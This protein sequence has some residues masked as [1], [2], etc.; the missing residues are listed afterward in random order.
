MILSLYSVLDFF[1]QLPSSHRDVILRRAPI[2]MIAIDI[3]L[4]S[5]PSARRQREDARTS[6]T[7]V[8]KHDTQTRTP[9]TPSPPAARN[10]ELDN[11]TTY[12]WQRSS[13]SCHL[14]VFFGGYRDRVHGSSAN[15]DML[16]R[17]KRA[18]LVY[19]R[20]LTIRITR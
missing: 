2:T 15:R 3:L 14:L 19:R 12:R 16:R 20:S 7:A 11:D 10:L 1:N 9:S 18:A 6:L 17:P 4:Y 8:A 5:G 13:R